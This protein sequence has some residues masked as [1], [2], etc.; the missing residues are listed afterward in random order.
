[1]KQSASVLVVEDDPHI[2]ALIALLLEDAGYTV[3]AAGSGAAARERVDA[4]GLDL[5]ILDWMLPDMQGVHLCRLI[6]SRR[7]Q[8]FLPILMLTARGETADRVAGLDAGADDYLVKPFDSD[9]LLARV[10]ALL[11]I[12]VAER[13]RSDALVAL[14]RQ[15]AELQQAYDQL[16]VAQAQLVQTS[17]LAALGELVAGVA[18]E[19]NNPLAIILGNAELL[20]ELP[21]EEDRRAIAQIIAATYRV[22]RVVHSLATFAQYGDVRR[23]W[24]NPCD[25]IERVLDVRREALHDAGIALDLECTPELP[26]LW[27][28]GAQLQQAILN[29]LLN[30]EHALNGHANPRIVIRAFPSAMPVGPPQVLPAA[31]APAPLQGGTAIAIDIADNGPGLPE[32]IRDRLFEP[33]VTTKPVGQGAGLGLS[34][35]YG[36][37][38][39][40]N[41]SLE[42]AS[43]P[44][45]GTTFRIALPIQRQQAEPSA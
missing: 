30:A 36:I 29:L 23:G 18:H 44:G 32:E 2:S 7:D 11:R 3:S 20:P 12:R 27:L 25:L 33:F 38:V 41:G 26:N 40:H 17:K 24:H 4:G 14:E 19:L 28:D 5:L 15:H 43:A 34:T 21:G 35:A 13:E 10:R 8:P 22:H 9:E 6:K 37:I 31:A 45:R 39:Q 1:L 16:R 42:V